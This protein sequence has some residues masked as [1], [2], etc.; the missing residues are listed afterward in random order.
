M[1]GFVAV[2]H[3]LTSGVVLLLWCQISHRGHKVPATI[4][5]VFSYIKSSRQLSG[6]ALATVCWAVF[7]STV[8]IFLSYHSSAI[9][10]LPC[11]IRSHLSGIDCTMSC[12]LVSY[13]AS[14]LS[15][16]KPPS[17]SWL[18]RNTSKFHCVLSLPPSPIWFYYVTITLCN[19]YCSCIDSTFHISDIIGCTIL[20]LY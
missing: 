4:T 7:D 1:W 19:C 20:I 9:L 16:L 14:T 8:M 11:H 5:P 6:R 15:H 3:R 12:L 2:R 18:Y 13:L 17:P 10:I